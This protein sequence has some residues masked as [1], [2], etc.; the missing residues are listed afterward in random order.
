MALGKGRMTH[1]FLQN[2]GARGHPQWLEQLVLH[3]LGE[4]FAGAQLKRVASQVYSEIRV[5]VSFADWEHQPGFR[6]APDVVCEG[7]G[8]FIEVIP[9]RSLVSEACPMA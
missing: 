1:G 6:D 5:T 2:E 9:A 7:A 8:A 3:E 4:W